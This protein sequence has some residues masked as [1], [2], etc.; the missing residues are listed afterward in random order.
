MAENLLQNGSFEQTI[1]I[2]TDGFE[3][4]QAGE[5]AIEG[6]EII[7][8]PDAPPVDANTVYDIDIIGQVEGSSQFWGGSDGIQSVDLNGSPGYGGVEQTIETEP[9]QKYSV[10]FD[11]AGNPQSPEGEK[12]K[13]IKVQALGKGLEASEIFSFDT[14]GKTVENMGWEQKTWEFTAT[15]EETTLQFV[16]EVNEAEG[17]N[18][19]PLRGPALDNVVVAPVFE[20][21]TLV[22]TA[23]DDVMVGKDE[24]I[25]SPSEDTGEGEEDVNGEEETPD[26]EVDEIPTNYA[27]SGENGDDILIGQDGNDSLNGGRNDDIL[28]GRQ[29]NDTLLGGVG[30]D[31][32][33]GGFGNDSLLGEA[34]NDVLRGGNDSDTLEGGDGDDILMGG[35]GKDVLV[36]GLG[37]DVLIGG[38]S[39]DAFRY[40]NVAEG[41]DIITDFDSN[42]ENIEVSA[43]GFGGGLIAGDALLP[44]QFVLGSAATDLAQRFI[45]DSTSGSLFFD[46]NGSDPGQQVFIAQF[47]RNVE[48]QI[49]VLTNENI[50]VIF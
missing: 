28:A 13:Q 41:G 48:G 9:G 4:L 2:G 34:G 1:N 5:K 33:F 10:T 35:S 29:G 3:P 6:W 19:D 42:L 40:N 38:N 7:K 36:G 14:T 32:L 44:E 30:D 23:E 45:Y 18:T 46:G 8:A 20:F 43:S 26:E 47:G 37:I 49:P 31:N 11:M 22:G 15:S 16:T 39:P 50:E 24:N 17:I 12:V 25:I 27:M 21:V